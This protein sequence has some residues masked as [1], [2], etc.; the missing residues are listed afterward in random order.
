VKKG[1]A[2]RQ[3]VKDQTKN[4]EL[5]LKEEDSDHNT[6][7]DFP[8][9]R[10]RRTQKSVASKEFKANDDDPSV[11]DEANGNDSNLRQ[12]RK[13]AAPSNIEDGDGDN[14]PE[15]Q[16]EAYKPGKASQKA[17]VV[18][19]AKVQVGEVTNGKLYSSAKNQKAKSNKPVGSKGVSAGMD[20]IE[21]DIDFLASDAIA[22]APIAKKAAK[23]GAKKAAPKAT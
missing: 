15:K 11:G 13:K 19:K 21:P 4:E 10:N 23:K 14:D 8:Q 12:G 18:K 1:R 5:Y 2:K 6:V 9:K 7:P 20:D 3:K 16:Q 22:A 17:A